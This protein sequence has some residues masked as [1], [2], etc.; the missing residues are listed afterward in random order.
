MERFYR[1]SLAFW[2]KTPRRERLCCRVVALLPVPVMLSYGILCL[3]LLLR[4]DPRLLRYLLVPAAVLLATGIRRFLPARRPFAV[5]GLTPLQP[6]AP[7]D[8]FPSR[9]TASATVIALGTLWLGL[10]WGWV[11]LGLA[12]LVALSRLLAAL[13]FPRDLLGGA[14]LAG[15]FAWVGFWL[16]PF[17]L[18]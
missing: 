1:A 12:V 11:C 5:Y 7:N 18:V 2:R 10:W 3:G 9:H 13:H 16:I 14:A 15:L 6:H 8:S 17:P 4:R